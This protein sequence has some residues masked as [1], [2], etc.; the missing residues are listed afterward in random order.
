MKFEKVSYEQYKKDVLGSD[1]QLS[2]FEDECVKEYEE[3]KLPRRA[4][5]GSA[6]YDFFATRNISIA[7]GEA[8]LIH[9]GVRVFMPNGIFLSIHPR[10]GLGFKYR[11][12]LANTTG[13][14]DSDYVDAA[15]EGHIAIKLVN[16]GTS[17]VTIRKGQAV[18][19]GIFQIFCLVDDDIS[20]G[21]RVGGFGSTDSGE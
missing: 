12:G 1:V 11:I 20:D 5:G 19:Q 16:N 7:P 6:G 9:T 21:E 15:N 10:S 18:A 17:A 8:C 13:I 14:I 2:V 3:I 4:T